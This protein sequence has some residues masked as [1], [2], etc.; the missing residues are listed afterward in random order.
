MPFISTGQFHEIHS[1]LVRTQ[2]TSY[3]YQFP[4]KPV[5][6]GS[7]QDDLNDFMALFPTGKVLEITLDYLYND[8]EVQ[9]FVANM[10]SE[11]F[12]KIHKTVEYLKEYKNVSAFIYMNLKPQ[13]GEKIFVRFKLVA[14]FLFSSV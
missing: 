2:V 8:K 3:S 14:E 10:Q 1:C 6:N 7:L 11:E 5:E 12:P 9:E 13:C 4:G